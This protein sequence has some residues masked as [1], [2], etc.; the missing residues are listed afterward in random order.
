MLPEYNL[1]NQNVAEEIRSTVDSDCVL[2][3][4]EDLELYAKDTSELLRIREMVVQPD[5]TAKIAQLIKLANHHRF[6][7]TP[8]GTGRGLVGG[9]LAAHGGVV[10][11]FHRIRP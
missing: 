7:G 11:K 3:N 1:I 9:A 5:T 4:A 2:S 6:P 8:S 10:S